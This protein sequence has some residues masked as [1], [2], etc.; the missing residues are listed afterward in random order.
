MNSDAAGVGVLSSRKVNSP[1]S[2]GVEMSENGVWRLETAATPRPVSRVRDKGHVRRMGVRHSGVSIME[3]E[4]QPLA[5]GRC[6]VEPTGITGLRCWTPHLHHPR[7]VA[8]PVEGSPPKQNSRLIVS[9][10]DP[11][12][13]TRRDVDELKL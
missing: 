4:R 13:R 7:T 8:R 5:R 2:T 11:A 12:R 6:C 3:R 9:A 1:G 10:T